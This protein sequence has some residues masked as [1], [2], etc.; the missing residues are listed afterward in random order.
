MSDTFRPSS[1]PMRPALM[2]RMREAITHLRE[3]VRLD[4][5]NREYATNLAAATGAD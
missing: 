5:K 4:P 1:R 3:A 2:G